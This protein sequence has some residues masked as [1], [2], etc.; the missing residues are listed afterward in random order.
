M[1][2]SLKPALAA[3]LLC[4]MSGTSCVFTHIRTPLDTDLQETRLGSKR[5]EATARSIAWLVAWGDAGTRAAAENSGITVLR[6]MDT[7][8]LFV[9]FG[10]YAS[11]TTI[12]YGD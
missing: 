8:L 12:V 6:Q 5:G 1:K 3:A 2:L 9:L 4:A 11:S 10:L 7:E